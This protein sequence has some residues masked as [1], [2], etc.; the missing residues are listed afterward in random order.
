MFCICN[1]A[2]AS[3]SQNVWGYA[4]ADNIGWISF[5]CDN[6]R[7]GANDCLGSD[8]GVNIKTGGC[9][10][11]YA[12]SDNLG[13]ISFNQ[14]D[15]GNAPTNETGNTT[16]LAQ[17]YEDSGATKIKGWA[18]VLSGKDS[19]TDGFDGWIKFNG[20]NIDTGINNASPRE[21]IGYAWGDVVTGWIQL[22]NNVKNFAVYTNYTS[23]LKPEPPT[24]LSVDLGGSCQYNL[25]FSWQYNPPL[26]TNTA[27]NPQYCA[28]VEI[29]GY[30]LEIS[31][32]TESITRSM[33]GEMNLSY[34]TE[35][36]YRI[37][38]NSDKDNGCDLDDS[39][40]KWSNWSDGIFT[41]HPEY[42]DPEFEFNPAIGEFRLDDLVEF[43]NGTNGENS[44]EWIIEKQTEENGS[45]DIAE[46]NTDYE[47]D[48]CGFTMSG[49]V[50]TPIK[51]T[52]N[53]DSPKLKF[54]TLAN[55]AITLR[56]TND[57]ATCELRKEMRPAYEEIKDI[58]PDDLG[59][60][61]DALN[62]S[63]AR[64]G[65]RITDFFAQSL[66]GLDFWR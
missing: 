18:R 57:F 47:Y 62:G 63:M 36:T 60:F 23:T 35:Y 51:C 21:F 14:A 2:L 24:D 5:N 48:D 30:T 26:N 45:F 3:E 11:G 33:L 55:Y 53:S 59:D 61:I 56:A 4:W 64:F 58:G 66:K 22:S 27:D 9:F 32:T 44:Y 1:I 65:Q 13:W 37:R 39:S 49:S 41:S 12:W 6:V 54:L 20:T 29:N 25:T 50:P 40:D 38:T 8:Y 19:D 15:T 7:N 52:K 10:E 42:P 43:L 17:A 31:G 28:Q 16:C 46:E 34:N